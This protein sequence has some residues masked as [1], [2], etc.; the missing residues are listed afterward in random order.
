MS[1]SLQKELS[2]SV[3]LTSVKNMKILLVHFYAT[4]SKPILSTLIAVMTVIIG[5]F[6][7]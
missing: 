3:Y 7:C 6:D 4:K 5:Q 1:F 2:S